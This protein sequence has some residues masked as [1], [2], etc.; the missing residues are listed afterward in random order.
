LLLQSTLALAAPTPS[1]GLDG[2]LIKPPGTG[3]RE[4]PKSTPGILEGPFDAA[5]YA[6]VTVATDAAPTTQALARDGFLTGYGRTWVQQAT[7]HVLIEIVVAFSGGDGARRWLTSSEVADKADPGYQ[8]S[9]SVSGI[10]SYYGERYANATTGVYEDVFA[11]VKGN[12][13]FLVGILSGSD[14]LADS[15]STQTLKQYEFAPPNTIPPAQWP[16]NASSS[17]AQN[18]IAYRLGGLTADVLI[19]ALLA[20]IVLLVVGLI[21]RAT[22]RTAIAA[23]AALFVVSHSSGANLSRHDTR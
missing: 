1:P 2:I 13:Y 18:D 23:Y 10:G 14:D 3:Y 17:N 4:E 5:K 6:E 9:I 20:G 19:L 8:R 11:F 16:E 15:A 12:D 7:H 22:R 21:R